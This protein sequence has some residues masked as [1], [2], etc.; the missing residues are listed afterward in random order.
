MPVCPHLPLL[1]LFAGAAHVH[2]L[3]DF[4][5]SNLF[6]SQL[7]KGIISELS[8]DPSSITNADELFSLFT[9]FQ[10]ILFKIIKD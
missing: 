5:Y 4:D 9:K 2:I 3:K 7:I 6:C 8:D 1:D 10:V